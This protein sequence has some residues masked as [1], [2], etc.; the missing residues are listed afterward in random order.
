MAT[1]STVPAVIASLVT[2]LNAA[3]TGALAGVKAYEA[4]PG[5]DA[6]PQMLV[7]G[8][9]TW[10]D[11]VIP[12]IKAGRKQRQEDWEVAFEVWVVGVDGTSPTTPAAAR[13]KAFAILA[14]AENLLAADVT[15][16]TDFNTVQ[17]VQI[18]PKTAGPHTFEKGWAY[19]ITGVFVTAARLQ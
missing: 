3:F 12:T 18:R 10:E 14:A 11:Y 17:W 4:W 6:V 7:F 1:T 13:D 19:I 5:P 15:A 9:I 16:G 2:D 8:E